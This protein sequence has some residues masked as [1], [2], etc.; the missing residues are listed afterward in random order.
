MTE[1]ILPPEALARLTPERVS[2]ALIPLCVEEAPTRMILLAG[3]GSFE[4][5]HITMTQGL[6][7]ADTAR[8]GAELC[9][10]LHE[11]SDRHGELVPAEGW[12]QYQLEL[13]KAS[14]DVVPA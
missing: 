5:A 10:R 14:G 7:I 13:Q 4:A 1:G 6:H 2:P 11:V 9:A 8:A 12:A 3:A